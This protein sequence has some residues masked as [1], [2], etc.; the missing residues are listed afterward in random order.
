MDIFKKVLSFFVSLIIILLQGALGMIAGT[1]AVG[2]TQGQMPASLVYTGVGIWLGV[3]IVGVPALSLRKKVISKKYLARL[4]ASMLGAAIPTA[5]LI[6]IGA[7][8]GY[9]SPRI[10]EGLG[11]QMT[12]LAAGLSILGFY[13]P[14]WF[15]RKE[16]DAVS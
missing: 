13:A 2:M 7:T 5:I 8:K 3:L 12:L 9:D 14:G 10:S 4:L 16:E 6:Y 15:G 1:L 11:M